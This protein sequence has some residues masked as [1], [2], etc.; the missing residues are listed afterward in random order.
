MPPD[1]SLADNRDLPRAL[2]GRARSPAELLDNLRLRLSQL[3]ENHPSAFRET[4]LG[5]E[6]SVG[7][8]RDGKFT[9][10]PQP[11][12]ER[13]RL[14][15]AA[16]YDGPRDYGPRDYGPARDGFR[17]G[18]AQDGAQQNDGRV[19]AGGSLG[20]LIRAVREAG[21]TL[22]DLADDGALGDIDLYPGAFP[23]SAYSEPYRPWFMSGDMGTPWFAAGEVTGGPSPAL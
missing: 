21:D 14:R 7:R 8:G 17:D 6:A 18:G 12:P 13:D 9:P 4:Y 15:D 22:A 2:D 11:W 1:R 23:G 5:P 3:P 19:P 16:Q 10:R 20:D